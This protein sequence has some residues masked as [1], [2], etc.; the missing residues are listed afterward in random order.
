MKKIIFT[1]L[2]CSIAN[3]QS[4]NAC[5]CGSW[6]G[7]YD[8]VSNNLTVQGSTKRDFIGII[9][10]TYN[11]PQSSY[12]VLHTYYQKGLQ[13]V[14]DSIFF[15]IGHATCH[16]GIN[17]P[18]GD[19]VVI[20]SNAMNNYS[21]ADYGYFIKQ[22]TYPTLRIMQGRV[23]GGG[24]NSITNSGYPLQLF[25]D[26]LQSL[27]GQMT[28]TTTD[29]SAYMHHNYTVNYSGNA[30]EIAPATTTIDTPPYTFE[31]YNSFGTVVLRRQA[32]AHFRFE[33]V[34]PAGIYIYQISTDKR[35]EKNKIVI[36][37]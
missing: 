26:S 33:A 37:N 24:P 8:A 10:K 3:I 22:C 15:G 2:L 6:L 27:I 23:Y 16:S 9:T 7:F 1:I 17:I 35:K 28:V 19:T 36:A 13:P 32:K 25:A 31:L 30:F 34:L 20:I 11:S 21:P 14:G 29:L 4:A 5:I 12:Q 18:F